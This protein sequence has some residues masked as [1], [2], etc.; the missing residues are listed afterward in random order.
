MKFFRSFYAHVYFSS[1]SRRKILNLFRDGILV[2]MS[3]LNEAVLPKIFRGR[4]LKNPALVN[5]IK[6]EQKLNGMKI[7]LTWI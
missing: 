5:R 6:T 1:I 4:N 7:K 3:G 2:T